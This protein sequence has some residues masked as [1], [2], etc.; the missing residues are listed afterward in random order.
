METS[1]ISD[2]MTGIL[3]KNKLYVSALAI[4]AINQIARHNTFNSFKP[5]KM[6]HI[7][8][9]EHE[10]ITEEASTHSVFVDL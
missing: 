4:I 2:G 10:L 6:K 8:I 9:K 3:W 5:S 1:E 7:N